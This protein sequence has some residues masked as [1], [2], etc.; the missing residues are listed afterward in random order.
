MNLKQQEEEPALQK[1]YPPAFILK[2]KS[3][4][5]SLRWKYHE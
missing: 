5:R 1:W 2:G 4:V 3:W